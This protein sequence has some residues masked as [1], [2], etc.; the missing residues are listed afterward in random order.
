MKTVRLQFQHE[1]EQPTALCSVTP[2]IP[3]VFSPASPWL[4]ATSSALALVLIRAFSDPTQRT[5]PAENLP[6]VLAGLA[7]C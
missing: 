3:P 2:P 7:C 1:Q 5:N 4:P 6:L